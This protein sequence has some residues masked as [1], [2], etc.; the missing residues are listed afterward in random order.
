[1]PSLF[2][3]PKSIALIGATSDPRKFGNAVTKNIL[4]NDSLHCDVYLISKNS[5]KIHGKK[6][7]R[8]LSEV[9]VDIDLVII[10]VPARIV[11]IVINQCIKRNVKRIIIVTAGFGEIDDLGKKVEQE[12]ANKCRRN[13]IRVM[14][15]NCV[16]I[17][18]LDIGLNA[19]FIQS[20]PKG[21]IGMVSQ[22]GSIGCACF[23]E[24]EKW[25]IGCSKFAS[26]GNNVDLSYPDL[27]D[28]FK[29]DIHSEI[30]ALY[31]EAIKKPKEFIKSLREITPIKPVISLKGGKNAIGM[32]TAASHTGSLASNYKIFKTV[33][34]QAGVI[35]CENITDFITAMK[36]FTGCPIPKGENIG[37][38]TN[39]GGTAVLFCDQMERFGLKLAPFSHDFI[40]KIT[41]H[42]IPLV[43]KINPLDMI[44]GAGEKEYYHIAKAMLEDPQI[45]IVLACIVIPP[46]LE[47]DPSE[48]FRGLVN[49]WNEMRREK[50]LVVLNLFGQHSSRVMNV[51]K[52]EKVT[53]FSNP[54]N[55][56]FSIKLLIDRMKFLTHAH[57]S[58][59]LLPHG[60]LI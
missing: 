46:F 37:I 49:A 3:N 51:S 44:A 30:I 6:C 41:P 28:Y 24:M 36:I 18:N 15:P 9:P 35:S 14:G 22:S 57:D 8:F 34:N 23:Y 48:H 4:N 21:E 54:H 31:T 53:F 33:L 55:A 43:K 40:E 13:G 25:G 27:L 7:Y 1:M 17:Q 32:E 45:D 59:V 12:I 47:M 11:E 60:D 29:T 42:I 2:F 10:L 52:E 26:I 50:P 58:S 20:A 39:S 19:S 38:M 56:A 16:G 5:E